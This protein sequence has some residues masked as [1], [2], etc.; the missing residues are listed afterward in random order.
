MQT[1]N[2]QQ[3]YVQAPPGDRLIT[4]TEARLSHDHAPTRTPVRI[5]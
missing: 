2:P 4:V 1:L 3:A 5:M